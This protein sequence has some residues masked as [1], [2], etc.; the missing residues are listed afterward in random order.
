MEQLKYQVR[1]TKQLSLIIYYLKERYQFDFAVEEEGN[2]YSVSLDEKR[3]SALN[4][5]FPDMQK[6][7]IQIV[8]STFTV[9]FNN[10][11]FEGQLNERVSIR[12]DQA[13]FQL[14]LGDQVLAKRYDMSTKNTLLISPQQ[15]AHIQL[16]HIQLNV[17]LKKDAHSQWQYEL[18]EGV[19]YINNRLV[20][21]QIGTIDLGDELTFQDHKL[22]LTKNE[23]Q[24]WGPVS[25]QVELQE[26]TFS[27]YDYPKDYPEYHRSPRIIYR[28]PEKKVEVKAPPQLPKKP[29][30]QLLKII[31]P[32]LVM[33]TLLVVISIFQPRGLYIVLT[34]AMSLLTAV[35]SIQ[36]Y[37]TQ[38]REYRKALEERANT[39]QSY[40]KSKAKDL[41]QDKKEQ[42]NGQHYHYP[43]INEI[44]E[45]TDSLNHRIY[46]KTPGHFDFLYYRLGL[47]RIPNSV[48]LT[49]SNKEREKKLDDLE[50]QGYHL[51]EQYQSLDKMPITVNLIDAP[52]GYIGPRK[53]VIEQLQL[54]VNQLA[55]FHSYHEVQ[56]ITIFPEEEKEDWNWMRWLPHAKLSNIN[57]RGFVYNQR[58]RD[59]VLNSLYQILKERK[60]ALDEKKKADDGV[61]FSPQYVVL[62]TDEK[63]ILD[64]MI[65]EFFDQNPLA[66]GCSIIFVQDVLSSLSQNVQTVID[67]RDRN[68]GMLLMENGELKNTAFH[69]EHFPDSFDKEQIPRKLAP[70]KHLQSIKNGVP[71]TVTFLEMYQ[72]TRFEDLQVAK[73]WKEHSPHKTLAVPI[74]LRAMNDPV[75]LNLHEKAHGPHGLV[76]GTTGSGKS[77]L[78]QSY[79]LSLAVNF[80]PHDVAFLLIDYKGGG[81]ANLFTHLP[82]LLGTITNLDGNQ[83]LRA[84]S[85]IKA[86]L[87][88]RQRL[89][90]LN[91]VNHINQYQKLVKNGD[92]AEPLPHLFLISDEFAELKSEQPDFMKELV[93]TARIGRSLGIHLILAT[94]KPTGVV[95]DQIWS[96]SR[97]KIALKVADRA[98]SMEMLRTPDASEITQVGRGYMQVGNNEIYEL[99]QSAWSGADYLPDKET[100]QIEDHTIYMVNDLGQYEILNEDLSGLDAVEEVKQI[101]TELVAVIEGIQKE[102]FKEKIKPIPKPWLPPLKERIYV[103]NL[104]EVQFEEEW[105]KKKAPLKP[106]IGIIDL[107][108]V[109]EQQ[110]LQLDLRK[111]GHVLLYASPG[112]GKSTFLQT[113]MLDLARS[114]NPEQVEMYL[115]DF[116]TNGL[117]PLKELPHVADIFSAD[118]HEKIRKYITRLTQEIKRRKKLLSQYSVANIALYEEVSGQTEPSLLI[119]VDSYEGIKGFPIEAE[120][121]SHLIQIAREGASLGIHIV[122]TAGRQANI[123]MNLSGNIKQQFVLKQNADDE[124]RMVVGRTSLTI[125][126]T[127][128]RGLVRMEKP[129]LLQVALPARG[130]SNMA[131]I[132]GMQTEVQ[133]M[134]QVWKGKLPVPIPMV[135]DELLVN[136]FVSNP[137]VIETLAEKETLVVGLDRS[138]ALPV[139]F[140]RNGKVIYLSSGR[141][142]LTESLNSL[143][144]IAKTT[145]Q[146]TYIID[147][148]SMPLYKHRQSVQAYATT[149]QEVDYV[150]EHVLELIAEREE[151][152]FSQFKQDAAQNMNDFHLDFT[153]IMLVINDLSTI[154][155]K[156]DTAVK[157]KID[158]LAELEHKLG[159]TIIFGAEFSTFNRDYNDLAKRLKATKNAVITMNFS[160]QSIYA[161]AIRISREKPLEQDEA[162]LYRDGNVQKIKFPV[163]TSEG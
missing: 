82:H 35:F 120:F 29:S 112:Y 38:K 98:D 103:E 80:H 126:D 159:I 3:F 1:T 136:D 153:P 41:Y 15:N 141:T 6:G 33:V 49:Y 71:D 54:L 90:S 87:K 118:E 151:L 77:E 134:K 9:Q 123:R 59:Q 63:L 73:R 21:T 27:K 19:L 128:G 14:F 95:D 135:P 68:T 142:K 113:I 48:D 74:G 83:S 150:I 107:P 115:L 2:S 30:E 133:N 89:F 104:H 61:L 138:T 111:D 143:L 47:G 114:Q 99:F 97:F 131:L 25:L 60:S 70:L 44:E 121:E 101:P 65:M 76:A 51:F 24:I 110:T 45:L 109:Q 105:T 160:E 122:M 13:E 36:R 154:Y 125:D 23:V 55:F 147:H 163:K 40:L 58:S 119:A 161:P 146:R 5:L 91:N 155:D 117:L 139:G 31:L 7:S 57:V 32:P 10:K 144:Q 26:V 162:Y 102:V 140:K 52:V 46:E 62:V 78:I 67:I 157:R 158:Q 4:N 18:L 53:L 84:L 37:F 127:P 108:D 149:D 152:Y 12:G 130:E 93:S 11:T 156:L 39:Y 124:A 50:A 116:G 92:V 132:Q 145:E 66:L 16:A 106:I 17:I 34:L 79:I 96:N 85:S 20:E 100:Q 28:N 94:Q 42:Q 137:I 72:A 88:R 8:G 86:E 22:K 43:S 56:F 148:S 64:H 75:Q 129:E 69:L 81:M